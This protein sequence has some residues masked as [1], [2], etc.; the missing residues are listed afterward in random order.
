MSPASHSLDTEIGY[1]EFIAVHPIYIHS[2]YG[3]GAVHGVVQR[4]VVLVLGMSLQVETRGVAR[5]SRG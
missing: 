2:S 4:E 3:G 1:A 5:Q